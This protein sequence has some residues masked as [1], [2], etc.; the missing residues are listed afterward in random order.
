MSLWPNK[1][2]PDPRP[3]LGEPYQRLAPIP[4]RQPA[5]PKGAP[6]ALTL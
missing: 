2:E 5:V 3:A 6:A 4:P 1:G